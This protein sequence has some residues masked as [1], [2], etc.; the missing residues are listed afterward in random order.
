MNSGSTSTRATRALNSGVERAFRAARGIERE[1]RSDARRS[2]AVTGRRYARSASRR[3]MSAAHAASATAPCVALPRAIGNCSCV[4]L[5]RASLPAS[6]RR[7]SGR[8]ADEDAAAARRI[9]DADARRAGPTIETFV[10]PGVGACTA[11]R[12]STPC[13]SRLRTIAAP[14]VCGPA[15]ILSTAVRGPPR[16]STAARSPLTV[17]STSSSPPSA[18]R[19]NPLPP[20]PTRISYSASS[21]KKC[22]NAHA[23]A[24]AERLAVQVLGLHEPARRA[25]RRDG[26]ARVRVADGEPADPRGRR[27]VARQQRRRHAERARDVVEA[28]ARVV[29]GQERRRVDGHVEQVAHGVRV[30]G[31]VQAV[32]RRRAGIRRCARGRVERVLE[33][34]HERVER[35]SPAGARP[36]AASSARAAC[37]SRSPKRPHRLRGPRGSVD[38]TR[39]RRRARRRCGSR[40]SSDRRAPSGRRRSARGERSRYAAVAA[41]RAATLPS[42][43]IATR[44]MVSAR[45]VSVRRA[46][47]AARSSRACAPRRRRRGTRPPPSAAPSGLP[48]RRRRGVRR[49]PRAGE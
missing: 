14:S 23:A 35:A 9:A 4:A 37:G 18:S 29:A 6:C 8:R 46:P 36:A 1:Q 44:R 30:L 31:A 45:Q 21:G 39:G 3:R 32:Q 28:G 13:A 33:P 11:N 5:P 20:R 27:D 26:R 2:S 40:R 41:A 25:V 34:A 48:C 16:P 7:R 38:R 22:R 19:P 17:I 49:S 15:G 12:S 24:R 10:M 43:T 42:P 47:R